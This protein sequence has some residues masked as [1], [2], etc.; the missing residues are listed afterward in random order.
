[1]NFIYLLLFTSF[2]II[3]CSSLCLYSSFSRLDI[4]V[5]HLLCSDLNLYSLFLRSTDYLLTR[6]LLLM[7]GLSFCW[8]IAISLSI[9][10][11][12]IFLLI[13]KLDRRGYKGVILGLY[14]YGT[15]LKLIL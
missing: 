3:Y 1:M 7:A 12:L 10:V 14:I 15:M 6:K 11:G 4:L 9:G 5:L 2:S 13:K 8:M